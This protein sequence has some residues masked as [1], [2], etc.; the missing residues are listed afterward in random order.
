MSDETKSENLRPGWKRG[1]SG[2]PRGRPKGSR[3]RI[4][5][6]AL[7]A[8]E[9]GAEAIARRMVELAKD[10]DISAARLVLERLVPPARERPVSMAMPDTSTAEGIS[11]AQQTI[12]QA[13][14]SGELLPGEAATLAGIVE[15]R[16][17]ALET[18]E[19]ER[20]VAALEER[21]DRT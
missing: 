13:A 16:R 5:L 12:L 3:N 8:M 14:A 19:L 2:N 4:T 21:H 15:T 7:A 1:Q 11:A 18:E 9:E 17:K 6:V 10:G 20:R